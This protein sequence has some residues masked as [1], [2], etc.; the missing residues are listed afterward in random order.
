MVQLTETD[1]LVLLTCA[2][3]IAHVFKLVKLQTALSDIQAIV[4]A[5][6]PVSAKSVVDSKDKEGN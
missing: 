4:T 5:L 2:I 6:N 1:I 3:Q